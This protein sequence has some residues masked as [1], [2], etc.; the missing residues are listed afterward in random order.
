[1]L[2]SGQYLKPAPGIPYLN[3]AERIIIAV[4]QVHIHR[5]LTVCAGRLSGG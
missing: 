5:A 4:D 3:R 2:A 1:M